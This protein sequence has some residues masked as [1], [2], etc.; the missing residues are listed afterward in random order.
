MRTWSETIR[1]RSETTEEVSLITKH[2]EVAKPSNFKEIKS[3]LVSCSQDSLPSIGGYA[4]LSFQRIHLKLEP[5]VPNWKHSD[6]RTPHILPN[7]S[8]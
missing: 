8:T 6:A 2:A 7:K 1:D 5:L 4:L 3:E